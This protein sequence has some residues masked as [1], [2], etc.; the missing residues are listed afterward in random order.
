MSACVQQARRYGLTALKVGASVGLVWLALHDVDLGEAWR[1]LRGVALWA[2]SGLALALVAKAATGVARWRLVLRHLGAQLSVGRTLA[3]LLLGAFF[4]QCLPSSIGGDGVRVFQARR[5]GLALG[6]AARSVVIDR[7]AGLLALLVLVAVGA[8]MF[9]AW[10][11]DVRVVTVALAIGGGGL[12]GLGVLAWLSRHDRPRGEGRAARSLRRMGADLRALGARPG[13]A[14][15]IMVW[16]VAFQAAQVSVAW[17]AALGLGVDLGPVEA[18]VLLPAVLLVTMVPVS[19]AGWGVRE[20]ATVTALGVVGVPAEQAVVVSVLYGLA[21]L[22]YGLIGGAIAWLVLGHDRA[23][24][25][26]RGAT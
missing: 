11:G 20:V 7:L 19:V 4:N 14:I 25:A 3:I 10:G 24:A 22:I 26:T 23:G 16:A 21:H 13:T 12:V 2:L 6:V 8:P 1:L 9:H 15:P 5:S 17:I 18:L